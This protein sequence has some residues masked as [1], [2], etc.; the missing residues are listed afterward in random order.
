MKKKP[1]KI[2]DGRLKEFNTSDELPNQDE[3]KEIKSLMAYMVFELM[4]LGIEFKNK[5]LIELLKHL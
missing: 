4:E 3:I 2:E 5:R 1:V